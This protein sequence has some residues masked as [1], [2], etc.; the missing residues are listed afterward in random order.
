MTG[1]HKEML[2][3]VLQLFNI[4]PDY[5]LEVMRPGQTLIS[6]TTSILEGLSRI[7]VNDKPDIMLVHGDTTTTLA[8]TLAGYYHCAKV[9]H[10][11]AY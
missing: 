11:E 9:G 7:L 3:Q 6:I 5:D 2:E 4:V 8:A 1:Q 10:V